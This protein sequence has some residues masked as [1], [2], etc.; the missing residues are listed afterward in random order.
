MPQEIDFLKLSLDDLIFF[1]ELFL[2]WVTDGWHWKCCLFF[3]FLKLFIQIIC[4]H[5]FFI[6][7]SF[8]LIFVIIENNRSLTCFREMFF[9]DWVLS[10]FSKCN[11]LA[12]FC[13][14]HLLEQILYFF[15]T[16]L[17]Y[18]S[19]CFIYHISVGKVLCG[20]LELFSFLFQRPIWIYFLIKVKVL[21]G[22]SPLSIL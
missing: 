18:F 10:K 9:E 16:I 5:R 13:C 22:K 15:W 8:A 20:F 2:F 17:Q 19:S 7:K 12:Y 14:E 6:F 3:K 4:D 21:K 11:P 1:D